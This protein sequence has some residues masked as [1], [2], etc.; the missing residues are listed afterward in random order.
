MKLCWCNLH[1]HR[2][3]FLW[4]RD[5]INFRCQS[6]P[7]SV[8]SDEN[9][10]HWLLELCKWSFALNYPVRCYFIFFRN[11]F[12]WLISV[13]IDANS[14]YHAKF[15]STQ[16]HLLAHTILIYCQE[17]QQFS[18]SIWLIGGREK[19]SAIAFACSHLVK[20]FCFINIYFVPS[21]FV[22]ASKFSCPGW[23][24]YHTVTYLFSEN[25]EICLTAFLALIPFIFWSLP[26][27]RGHIETM[28]FLP[29]THLNL[30]K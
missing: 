17:C 22:W 30:F 1:W 14:A 7:Y 20:I 4:E 15:I 27:G 23:K 6:F 29:S 11:S 24:F 21:L 10:D 12:C 3:D 26:W 2:I 13:G 9:A 18:M 5:I 28:D 25:I 16:F 8:S 19:V